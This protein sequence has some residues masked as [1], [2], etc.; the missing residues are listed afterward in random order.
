MEITGITR[1]PTAGEPETLAD[2][3]IGQVVDVDALEQHGLMM[4]EMVPT[5]SQP[6]TATAKALDIKRADEASGPDAAFDADFFWGLSDPAGST[7]A[8]AISVRLLLA[9]VGVTLCAVGVV[10][11]TPMLIGAGV[12]ALVGTSLV[13]D[14][15]IPLP[16]GVALAESRGPSLWAAVGSAF[17]LISVAGLFNRVEVGWPLATWALGLSI[18]VAASLKRDMALQT[19]NTQW[20]PSLRSIDAWFVG[21][22][23]IVGFGLRLYK[24]ETLPPVHGDEG[25]MGLLALRVGSTGSEFLPPF[26]TGFLDHPTL[27]HYLQKA[28]MLVFGQSVTG[29]RM[30]SAIFGALCIPA[31]YFVGRMSWSRRVGLVAAAVLTFSHIHVHFSRMA[32]NNIH[33]VLMGI[34]MVGCI[35]WTDR[36]LKK[37]DGAVTPL[38][39]TGLTCGLAQYFYYGSRLLPVVLAAALV[40]FAWRYRQQFVRLLLVPFGFFATWLPLVPRFVGAPHTFVSRQDGVSAFSEANRAAL[41]AGSIWDVVFIQLKSNLNFFIDGGDIS[42]FYFDG[43]PGLNMVAS[44]LFWGGLGLTIAKIRSFPNFMV[45]VWFAFGLVLGGVFT[46][47]SPS[48]TRL[49]MI[50]PAAALLA[51][52]AVDHFAGLIEKPTLT[53]QRFWYAGIVALAVLFGLADAN[54]YF[55]DYSNFSEN[56]PWVD[57]D[58]IGRDIASEADSADTFVLG[59]SGLFAGH[60]TLAFMSS[61]HQSEDLF[62][63]SDLAAMDNT[64]PK[65]FVVALPAHAEKM[66]RL[67][68]V[69][70]GGEFTNVVNARNDTLY[71][72]YLV[73]H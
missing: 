60:G 38:L 32:L 36:T 18:I 10:Q 73:D 31:I 65:L 6:A 9:L 33:S 30:N 3:G 40:V 29:I 70:P 5:F 27:Y 58:T 2:T 46:N 13:P 64:K 47:G 61:P 8:A 55:G 34:L 50:L 42:S 12:A 7:G 45:I 24:L 72:R 69:V 53:I 26:T 28:S 22:L 1:R 39:F 37:R 51:G 11:G 15:S 19:I 71:L 16:K 62:E 54:T 44:I 56:P 23:T 48:A 59:G 14:R 17:V 67:I 52:I 25:E 41:G 4:P 68:E 20:R 21:A 57:A 35:F 43:A 63:V 66:E 49:V